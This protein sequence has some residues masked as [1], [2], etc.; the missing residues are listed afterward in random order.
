MSE[1]PEQAPEQMTDAEVEA[2]QLRVP[3]HTCQPVPGYCYVCG[4]TTSHAPA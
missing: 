3:E 4:A 2:A 1:Q